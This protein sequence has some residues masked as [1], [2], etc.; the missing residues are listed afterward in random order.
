VL[1]AV[2][3]KILHIHATSLP[4]EGERYGTENSIYIYIPLPFLQETSS[5]KKRTS[6]RHGQPHTEK[7]NERDGTVIEYERYIRD[8]RR[9]YV[10]PICEPPPPPSTEGVE[11][12]M[13]RVN[14]YERMEAQGTDRASSPP[15]PQ[16]G[17]E[18]SS[19]IAHSQRVSLP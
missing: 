1:V 12:S 6:F 18:A 10:P 13:S 16:E 5:S 2:E 15:S 9:I 17:S 14:G 3:Y 8:K 4:Q 11:D 19:C 7:E